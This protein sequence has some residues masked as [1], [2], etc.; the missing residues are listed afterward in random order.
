MSGQNKYLITQ[1]LLSSWAWAFKKEGGY[2]E[3][4]DTL[5]RKPIAQTEAMLNG[6][7]FENMVTA[8]AENGELDEKHK[9]APGIQQVGDI[10]KG[11]AFQVHLYLDRKIGNTNFILHGILDNLKAGIIY[12]IKFSKTYE[13][14]KYIDSPQHPMYLALCPEAR[15]FTY[16]VSD[17]TWLYQETYTRDTMLYNIE[18]EVKRFTDYLTAHKLGGMY[19][20]NWKSLY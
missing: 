5:Q 18:D 10:V 11:G 3:F 9:W 2:D 12:D 7:Q 16:L 13:V 19:R 14:G 6:I 4:I 17:G 8:Y 15:Q 20:K 1:T